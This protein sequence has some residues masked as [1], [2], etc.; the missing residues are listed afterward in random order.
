M[1]SQGLNRK[2]IQETWQPFLDWVAAAPE[3]LEYARQ[4][5]WAYNI[6]G[7]VLHDAGKTHEASAP[8]KSA[9]RCFRETARLGAA[10][11]RHSS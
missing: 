3:D 2:E 11:P 7:H 6:L 4:L 10:D 1:L 8:F 9:G 5:A